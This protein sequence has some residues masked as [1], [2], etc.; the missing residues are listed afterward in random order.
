MRRSELAS[1]T[2]WKTEGFLVGEGASDWLGGSSSSRQRDWMSLK[3]EQEKRVEGEGEWERDGE[4]EED[5]DGEDDVL[6]IRTV[7]LLLL[8]GRH[9]EGLGIWE[10]IEQR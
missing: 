9:I 6:W 8:H 1:R 10:S 3:E 4:G 7:D 5:G 2:R